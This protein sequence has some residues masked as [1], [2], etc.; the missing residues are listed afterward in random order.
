MKTAQDQ[1]KYERFTIPVIIQVPE[2]SNLPVVP[3]DVSAGGFK[4]IVTQEPPEKNSIECS[5]QVADDV[6]DNCTVHIAWV[7]K[8]EGPPETWEVGLTIK[9]LIEDRDFLDITLHRAHKGLK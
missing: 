4:V 8:I 2:L 3:E 1:R 5:I 6:F 9:T 7:H